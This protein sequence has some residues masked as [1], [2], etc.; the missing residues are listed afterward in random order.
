MHDLP[1][2][3]HSAHSGFSAEHLNFPFLHSSQTLELRIRRRLVTGGFPNDCREVR[4]DGDVISFFWVF[5]SKMMASVG[6]GTP[7]NPSG[8]SLVSSCES[9]YPFMNLRISSV[10][11]LSDTK[12]GLF[13]LSGEEFAS[14]RCSTKRLRRPEVV[15]ALGSFRIPRNGVVWGW[16]V[17]A[18]V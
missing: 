3:K 7:L 11:P 18:G 4:D 16:R 12:L 5:L 1:N 17:G 2:L 10:A 15:S 14:F 9:L 6:S 8:R 13:R